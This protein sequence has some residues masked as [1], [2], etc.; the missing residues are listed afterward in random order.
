MFEIIPIANPLRLF[1]MKVFLSSL[2][3]IIMAM[4][5]LH[6]ATAAELRAYLA[7]DFPCTIR[8]VSVRQDVVFI[9]GTA[10]T[11]A[12]IASVPISGKR[13]P[14]V[15]AMPPIQPGSFDII[16]P[17]FDKGR[18]H[19]L[20][21]WQL[22]TP[23]GTPLSHIHYADEIPCR[24]GAPPAAAPRSKKGLGGWFA[25]PFPGELDELG[26][27]S[28]TVNVLLHALVSLK[29][30]Q[31]ATPFV[32]Q[33]KTYHA[34]ERV[35]AG[36][37][38]TFRQAEKRGAVVSAI[39]LVANP[40]RGGDAVAA[41]L[42]HPDAV[43]AGH[44]AMP[45]FT[46]REGTDLYGAILNLMAERWSRAGGPHGRVHHW[47]LHNEV[48]A[49][50]EWTNAGEKQDIEYMDLY[51]RSM[52]LMDLIGRQYDPNARPFISLTHHWA[53]P[54]NPR[55][56]G[57][58]RMLDLLAEFTAA[59]GGF[60]WG[61]AFH[62]YPQSLPEPRTWED[63]QATP[64][65]LTK[66]ITPRNIEVLDAYLR[67]PQF[68]HRGDIRPVQLSENGFNSKDY[69]PRTLAEQAAAM[70]YAW[71]KISGLS[72]ITTWEYHN[73]VDNRQEGGLRIGLRKFGDEPNDPHGKKPIWHLYQAL[74][75]PREN[76]ACTPY[77][78]VIGIRSWNEM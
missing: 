77:L 60:P 73:W 12:R 10:G 45:D 21:G 55:W 67:Q 11:E 68:L 42:A 33:G 4:D 51:H 40:S 52:R 19:L 53:E 75:T 22:V 38:E 62:P 63:S 43:E 31:G 26:I 44:Y 69:S 48:D 59:E 25:G 49:G 66:K 23:A 50:W 14:V 76:E 72:S 64:D 1:R 13:K 16:V 61:V 8:K 32:W 28:V 3:A 5:A 20:S 36:Y 17:R 2:A 34:R 35:L 15:P 56:Y 70:A 41:R 6:A 18:D 29:P 37:D 46:S 30:E 57:S 47:I 24:E 39:L 65:F 78:K 9:S 58:K 71:K 54:G 27:D 74:G 7:T